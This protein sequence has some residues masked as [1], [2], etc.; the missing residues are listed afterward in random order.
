LCGRLSFLREIDRFEASPITSVHLWFD[1]VLFEGDHLVLP[2]RSSQWIFSKGSGSSGHCYQV[3]IS[4]S[5]ELA[6]M[7]RDEVVRHVRRDIDELTES[8]HEAKL[9]AA[10]V[11]TEQRAVFSPTPEIEVR[12]PG[13]QTEVA[14]LFLAGDWTA[15]GWPATMEGAVRSGYLAAEAILRSIDVDRKILVGDLPASRLS[16]WLLGIR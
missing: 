9:V 11:I 5:R 1:R 4:G 6:E 12:R 10:K 3:V 7:S 15:T 8:A 2:G 13:Q 14:N 16:R